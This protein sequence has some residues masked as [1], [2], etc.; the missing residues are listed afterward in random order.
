VRRLKTCTEPAASVSMTTDP[1]RFSIGFLPW[2]TSS[3]GTTTAALTSAAINSTPRTSAMSGGGTNWIAG[4]TL[5]PPSS[6]TVRNIAGR[7]TASFRTLI[8]GG[9]AL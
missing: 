9:G 8:S 7:T 4:P 5:N 2:L 1:E 6:V 3:P